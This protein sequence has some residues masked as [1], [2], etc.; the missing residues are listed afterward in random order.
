[1]PVQAGSIGDLIVTTQNELGRMK[2]TDLVSDYQETVAMKEIIK[3]NKITFSSGPHV[4]FRVMFDHNNSARHVGLG[5]TAT[6]DIPNM[7]TF[8]VVPWR[9]T[10]W[11]YAFERRVVNMN[12]SPAKIFDYVKEQRIA[13]LAS[14]IILFE[15]TLWRLAPVTDTTAPFGIPYY[16]VKSNTAATYANNDGFNGGT[17]S[18]YSDVAGL[19]TTTYDRWR[20]YAT[21]YTA[22]TKDDLVRKMRRACVK[23]MFKPIVDEMPT[24][25]TGNKYGIYTNYSVLGPFEEVLEDQNE[26][27]GSDLAPKDGQVQFRRT[28]VQYVPEL[29]ND[30][31]NPVYGLNWGELGAMGLRDEWM[32]EETFEALPSQPAVAATHVDCTWNLLC[33][34]RRRQWVIATDTTTPAFVA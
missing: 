29:E 25:S 32:H 27:L 2:F 34:N 9:H 4:E 5:Y 18:G 21:Q 11:N 31:T 16:V 22:V 23:T 20:N 8:G 28:T 10:T 17:P 30:T 7:M 6:V 15:Q 24:Y 14:A 13:S 33:R 12:R 26:S 19:N 3:K 1:M